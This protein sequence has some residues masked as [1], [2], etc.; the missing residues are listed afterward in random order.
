MVEDYLSEREQAEALRNWWNENWRWIVGGLVLGFAVLGGYNYYTNY[1]EQKAL[2]AARVYQDLEAAIAKQDAEQSTQLLTT[3][4][5][6]YG[7]S[8]YAQQGRL[9]VAKVRVE[10][11]KN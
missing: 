2:S 1:R 5:S 3:L 11:G 7:S 8:A 9:A 4:T 6:T 10:A